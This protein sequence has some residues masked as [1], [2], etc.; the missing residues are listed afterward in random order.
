MQNP[1]KSP[2]LEGKFGFLGETT[3]SYWRHGGGTPVPTQNSFCLGQNGL[4]VEY[5]VVLVG[6]FSAPENVSLDLLFLE[7]KV[8]AK[9]RGSQRK[10]REE[11]AQSSFMESEEPAVLM[12]FLVSVCQHFT[13][14]L[15]L[16]NTVCQKMYSRKKEDSYKYFNTKFEETS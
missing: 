4:I 14:F 8:T 1:R 12:G 11:E 3:A 5:C 15:L 6:V 7:F 16:N 9:E 2:S 13:F 10:T